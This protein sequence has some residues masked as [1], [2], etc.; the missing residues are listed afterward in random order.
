MRLNVAGDE[1]LSIYSKEHTVYLNKKNIEV[2]SAT[3]VL[4]VIN[5]PALSYWANSLGFKH[6][7]IKK[8]LDETSAIGTDF[9]DMLSNYTMGKIIS[10]EHL[11][12]A[13]T[14]FLAFKEWAENNSYKTIISETSLCNEDFG[15]TLDAVSYINDE[16]C[17]VD[18]KTSKNI[19]SS[20]FLQLAGYSLLLKENLPETYS[21]VEK[22]GIISVSIKNGI[23]TKFVT[24][25]ELEKKYV[26]V[27]KKL[28]AF[29]QAWFNLNLNEFNDNIAK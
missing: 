28:L 23:Q 7:S 1:I 5:K 29:F 22:F 12:D 20:M 16:L 13:I 27:F 19:Y 17:V 9:H 26:P 21:K 4:K 2:P 10:G 15:G 18:Y 25:K 11:N 8:V 14:L 6:Q 24:K 3:T